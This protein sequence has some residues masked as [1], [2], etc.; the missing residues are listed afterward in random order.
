MDDL[1]LVVS[2]MVTIGTQICIALCIIVGL[3]IIVGLVFG[4]A[5]LL[6]MA[7]GPIIVILCLIVAAGILT[8]ILQ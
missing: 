3:L 7:I 8:R 4:A 6:A 5:S 1:G 2:L